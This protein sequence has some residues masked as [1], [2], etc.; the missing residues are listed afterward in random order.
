MPVPGAGP[1]P[2]LS[3]ADGGVSG[4]MDPYSSPDL[5]PIYNPEP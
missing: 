1:H 2:Q 3:G 5:I 4:G